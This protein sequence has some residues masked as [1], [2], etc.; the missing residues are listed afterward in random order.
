[1][2]VSIGDHAPSFS[3]RNIDGEVFSSDELAGSPALV[4]FIPFPFTGIC[5]TEL[6]SLRDDAA[7]L[8]G[9]EA[10]V[11]AIT[12]DTVPANREWSSQHEFGF[13]VLSDFWPHGATATAFGCFDE[14]VGAAT[15]TT[16][17][18]DAEGVVRDVIASGA[19]SAAREHDAY[20]AA[21]AAI[22]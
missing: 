18:L 3:L 16:Y 22:G 8:D 12:C 2:S 14:R 7:V 1:M 4:V 5:T 19:L 21:L 10:K 9:L 6:C 11:V 15:R 13:P 20:E 17:V